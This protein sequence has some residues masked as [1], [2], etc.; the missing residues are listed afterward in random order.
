MYFKTVLVWL[1]SQKPHD[2]C[3]LILLTSNF[4]CLLLIWFHNMMSWLGD[5]KM[6]FLILFHILV[7]STSFNFHYY[8]IDWVVGTSR[9]LTRAVV[10]G[11]VLHVT[12]SY[13]YSTYTY[14]SGWWQTYSWHDCTSISRVYFTL[15]K[16]NEWGI[17]TFPLHLIPKMHPLIRQKRES[18]G[19]AGVKPPDIYSFST[20]P[21]P[22]V[23]SLGISVDK[24]ICHFSQYL[25][26]G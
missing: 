17:L 9:L 2:K 8:V 10:C 21:I 6:P 1:F 3:L 20:S 11:S 12:L 13:G 18:G 5:H 19:N 7:W 16:V 26:C 24:I 15:Q 14:A 23:P 25:C 22:V 4:S